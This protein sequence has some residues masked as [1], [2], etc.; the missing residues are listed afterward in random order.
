MRKRSLFSFLSSTQ[1]ISATQHTTHIIGVDRLLYFHLRQGNPAPTMASFSFVVWTIQFVLSID[2]VA[3]F[4][5]TAATTVMASDSGNRNDAKDPNIIFHSDKH[6]VASLPQIPRIPASEFDPNLHYYHH[7]HH[8]TIGDE[9]GTVVSTYYETPVIVEGV[10]SK[11]ACEKLTDDLVAECGG[12]EVTLQRKRKEARIQ[13]PPKSKPSKLSKRD[14]RRKSKKN[15]NAAKDGDATTTT[16]TTSTAAAA[17]TTTTTTDMYTCSFLEAID[18]VLGESKHD[19][20]LL[21]FCE[22][23]LNPELDQDDDNS[24]SSSSLQQRMEDVR[25]RLFQQRSPTNR[26]NG[27]DIE[28]DASH[29]PIDPCWFRAYFPTEAR[30][31]DCVILAGE[32]ATSTLHRDPLEWTGT[33]L[34][35]DGTKVWRF[36]APPLAVAAASV[37]DAAPVENDSELGDY[38]CDEKCSAVAVIDG[39]LD[40]YRLDSIAWSDDNDDDESDDPLT[41]SAGWQ[42]DYSLFAHFHDGISSSALSELEEKKGIGHKL[43]VITRSAAD[44]D[45][46]QPDIPVDIGSISDSA[47]GESAKQTQPGDCVTVWSG[48]QK[49]GDMI[50]IPAHWW[51]QT[52]AMEA[53]LAIASQRCGAE[54]DSERVLRHILE[55]TITTS[56]GCSTMEN[57]TPGEQPREEPNEILSSL[58]SSSS[59]SSSPQETVNRL[60]DYLASLREE[61]RNMARQG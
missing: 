22:G 6:P 24:S 59:L 42:S 51:H 39:L 21:A 29:H 46:L 19:D 11:E 44:V 4:A 8:H 34:C 9:N 50:V 49:P 60:F 47:N 16:T 54:R 15:K 7:Y 20:A 1:T 57:S 56:L 26:E 53:S 12:I 25:E 17:T 33:N 41:L 13:P 5:A 28:A 55:T 10:L 45:R 2:A 48:V 35:L 58:R 3:S 31:T 43:D 23:L 18:L 32:G 30:P 27:G 61:R 40:S 52:Y 36:V 38:T 14:R 37:A